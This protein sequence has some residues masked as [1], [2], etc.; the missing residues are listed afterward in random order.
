MSESDL[1]HKFGEKIVGK[2]AAKESLVAHYDFA[3]NFLKG[4]GV[5][6]QDAE[7]ILQEAYFKAY[8]N[9]E[10]GFKLHE[11]NRTWFFKVVKTAE[12]TH[13][14][15]KRTQPQVIDLYPQ[16]EDHE[17]NP[18]T[19]A[20]L[21]YLAYDPEKDIP[22]S[23]LVDQEDL[24]M[25]RENIFNRLDQMIAPA[26]VETFRL[27]IEFGLTE[28]ETAEI[29]KL[30]LGTVKSQTARVKQIAQEGFSEKEKA[31][32]SRLLL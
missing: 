19:E 11:N 29:R 13:Y 26:A 30:P 3:L 1:T 2:E 21:D 20:T 4:R 25:I 18:D 32:F 6:P 31:V 12:G 7:D 5:S 10:K 8:R 9:I 17:D 27:R 24:R 23:H 28:K 22:A 15:K 14:R 16:N